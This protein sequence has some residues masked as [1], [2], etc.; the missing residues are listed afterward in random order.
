MSSLSN[1]SLSNI[2]ESSR[3]VFVGASIQA[4]LTLSTQ[5]NP[6]ISLHTHSISHSFIIIS[7]SVLHITTQLFEKSKVHDFSLRLAGTLA[8][9][10]IIFGNPASSN[11][12]LTSLDDMK[13]FISVTNHGRFLVYAAVVLTCENCENSQNIHRKNTVI[14]TGATLEITLILFGWKFLSS[15]ELD[16]TDTEDSAIASHA[17]SGFNINQIVAKAPAATGIQSTL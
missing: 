9:S 10:N 14:N 6:G 5:K 2:W 11:Q 8:E 13:S 4:I 15:R 3:K 7:A 17:N 12:I 16:T 1:T